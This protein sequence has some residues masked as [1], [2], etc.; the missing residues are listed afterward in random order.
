M[1]LGVQIYGCM[2]WFREDPKGFCKRLSTAGYTQIE[3]CVALNL[4]E[5][6][7]EEQGFQPVW[8]PEEADDF[9][10]VLSEYGLELTSCH[11]FGDVREDAQK[12]AALAHKNKLT[13]IVVNCPVFSAQEDCIRFAEGCLFLA[14]KLKA[15]GT[16]LWIH[17][18][19]PEIRT[20]FDGKTALEI[21][22]EHCGGKVGTQ[23][24]VGWVLYGGE[25]P[26][27]YLQKVSPYLRS[28]HYKDIRRE[29]R[30]LDVN[31]IH[32]ALGKGAVDWETIHR[33]AVEHHFSEVID[34][35]M[36]PEDFLR[37]LEES[38]DL[39]K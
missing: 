9:A 6:E 8:Q 11:I 20:K 32:I 15:V 18:G 37:D 24:D 13:Q 14:E 26:M 31:D 4:T 35:D 33:F 10:A 2:R 23:I 19:W 17:N 30:E 12:A 25:D 38:A 29:Y 22:L 7:L 28:I 3:P 16:E 39:L 36:S 5:K 34:Q 27:E 21:V 1:K